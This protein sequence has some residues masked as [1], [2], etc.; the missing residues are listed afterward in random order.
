MGVQARM[1]LR[2]QKVHTATNTAQFWADI[3]TTLLPSDESR[4]S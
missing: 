3:L 1:D 4:N 2:N